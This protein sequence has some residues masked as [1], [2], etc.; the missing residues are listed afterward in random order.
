MK[1]VVDTMFWISFCTLKES[2]RR[3][4]IER[5]LRQRV[6][7]FVSDWIL[8]EL[9]STLTEDLGRSS[10]YAFLARRAVLRIAKHVAL[11]ASSRAYVPGDPND[12]PIIQTALS[13]KADYLIT[14]DTEI[15][16]V[17]KVQDIAILTAPQWEE[18]LDP[19]GKP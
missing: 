13:A 14:A 9:T 16:K 5:A 10:R 12:D 6:R 15:L 1:V 11:P 8:D 18:K 7:L 2:Y 3:R 19:E 4:L 17:G